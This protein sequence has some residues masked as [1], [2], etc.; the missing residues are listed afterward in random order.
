MLHGWGGR[1]AQ[2]TP[3]VDPLVAAGHTAV[4]LDAPGHG[5]SP[6]PNTSLLHFAAALRSAVE[7]FGPAQCIIGHSLGGAACALALQR[8]LSAQSLVLLGAP[9]TPGETFDAF[10]AQLGIPARLRDRLRIETE[11]QSGFRF[12]HLVVRPPEGRQSLPAMIIHDRDDPQVDFREATRIAQTWP[13]TEVIATAGL[14]HYRLLRDDDVIARVVDFAKRA[15]AA[16]PSQV[17]ATR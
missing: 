17:I 11:R 9:S 7:S 14:G 1:G 2:F 8:G 13:D 12:E 6:A 15:P 4:V 5:E 10:L 3:F 16:N